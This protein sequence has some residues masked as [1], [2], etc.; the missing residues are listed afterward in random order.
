MK[1]DAKLI[2]FLVV[3]SLIIASC[4]Q[5]TP[6]P[7]NTP[8]TEATATTPVEPAPIE[9]VVE[10]EPLYLALVWHQHQPLYY[11][12]EKGVYTRPWVRVHATKDYYDMAAMLKDYP[13]LKVTI[14]LTPV[15][16]RQI[17]DFV[18][19]GAKDRY[20][21]L[22]EI[23]AAELTDADKDFILRRFFDANWD[24]IIKVHPGYAAL[25]D[26]RGGTDDAAIAAAMSAFTE[27][28]FRDLQIWFN[29]GWIDPDELAKEPLAGLVKKDAGF[30]E[31]DKRVLFSE[32]SRIMAAVVPVHREM[33]DAGQIEVITTPYAHP[34]LPLIYDSN[35]A[36]TG[37]PTAELPEGRF[38]YPQDAQVHLEKAVEIYREN[39]GRKPRGLWPG[40]GAVAQ[41]IVPLVANAGFEW[42]A[43]G[44]FVLAKSLGIDSFTRDSSETVQQADELY[45]PYQVDTAAN[46][47][48]AGGSVDMIFRDVTISDKIGF[49]YSGMDADAAAADVMQRLEDIREK[50][51]SDDVQGPNLVSIILDGENAWEN[52]DNDGKGFL[53]ALYR[54]LSESKTIKTVTPSEYLAMFPEQRKL[55]KLFPS[56]WFSPNYDTWI[57]E[58]EETTA[59]NYLLRTRQALDGAVRSGKVAPENIDRA[60]DFMYLA[61]GSDWFWWYGSDQDS[62]ADDYFDTGYRALLASVY[63]A[64]GRE[65]PEFVQ[66][67]ITRLRPIPSASALDGLSTPVVDGV[68]A[69]GEWAK[70]ANYPAE[71]QSPATGL[72]MTLDAKNLYLKMEFGES[73][74]PVERVG[75]Y[76][77]APRSETAYNFSRKLGSEPAQ[78]LTTPANLLVEWTAQDDLM[79][80]KASNTGWDKVEPVGVSAAQG[81]VR[82]FSIPLTALGE[83]EAGDDLRIATVVQPANQSLPTGG[84]AQ[85][86]LPEIS[87]AQVLFTVEDPQGDD[88]GPGSFEYPTNNV[89]L[90]GAF[91]IKSFSVAS[92][93]KNIIFKITFNGPV[94]NPWGSGNNLAIQTIDVYV[95]KDPGAGT[96]AR[97]MLPG[98]NAALT[99]GNGW[100]YALWAEGW[101]PGIFAPDAATLEPKPVSTAEMKI[102]VDTTAQSVSLRVPLSA[103]GE[104]DPA[105]WGFAAMVMGQEGFPS[106][107]VWRV[108]DVTADGGEWRFGGGAGDNTQTRIIDLAWGAEQELTQEQM[109]STYTSSMSAVEQLTPDDFAQV[110]L[111]RVP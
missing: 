20:W 37:N 93:E 35:L 45:R 33:Q 94:P 63:Q 18:N 107:G 43:T 106:T 98:R 32:I 79:L 81:Q 11:K 36:L 110:E 34:I 8:I 40:E 57:G 26:K 78:L 7:T 64:L 54:N 53:K 5:V 3:L 22:S 99:E 100:E 85:L 58:P 46:S 60:R 51:N 104:G 19:N 17:N 91:D 14:N 30:S 83:L 109:L 44:E 50:L 101:T 27:Q 67:P 56:A 89:F 16:L 77:L 4:A 48:I 25:L 88:H 74:T 69:E 1:K 6:A 42:M 9:P 41:E 55:D 75:F 28:D 80:Y 86:I 49:T 61:E 23:P 47:P 72:A 84:P 12:D 10:E 103:F 29:L 66:V 82:E 87:S 111:I 31:S 62:G 105:T 102:L 92:D 24:H 76:F 96:G 97:L 38:F 70:A 13:D 59:W 39:F 73:L 52:Y 71:G 65:V 2:S 15:L 68:A 108:R 95:D 21:E 90:P